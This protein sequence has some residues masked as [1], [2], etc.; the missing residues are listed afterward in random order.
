[1]KSYLKL[2]SVDTF[3]DLQINNKLISQ[4]DNAFKSQFFD[5]SEYL[6]SGSNQIDIVIK[7][8]LKIARDQFQRDHRKLFWSEYPNQSTWANP[9][10][11]VQVRKTQ[12]DFGWDWSP[13]FVPM[14]LMGGVTLE[15]IANLN[16][17]QMVKKDIVDNFEQKHGSGH[18]H[19]QMGD[20]LNGIYQKE[21]QDDK[22]QPES[23]VYFNDWIINYVF[24]TEDLQSVDCD[25][26]ID[27]EDIKGFQ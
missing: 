22:T 8:A 26:R 23:Q 1:M 15:S 9:N 17:V 13:T 16:Q 5:V 19:N 10:A 21:N 12:H 18:E 11:R 14:G 2:E 24:A 7:P 4:T 6:I 20:F 27:V 3:A 25:L